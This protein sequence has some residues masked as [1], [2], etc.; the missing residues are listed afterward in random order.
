MMARTKEE[1]DLHLK[2]ALSGKR[3]MAPDEVRV[4]LK[5]FTWKRRFAKMW[6]VLNEKMLH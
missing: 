2:E 1:F 3:Q 5:R 6:Q 4:L